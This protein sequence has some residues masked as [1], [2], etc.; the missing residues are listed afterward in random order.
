MDRSPRPEEV[1]AQYNTSDIH[2]L[3]RDPLYKP[4]RD[5]ESINP[6]ITSFLGRETDNSSDSFW[7]FFRLPDAVSGEVIRNVLF[8]ADSCHYEEN[9]E[10]LTGAWYTPDM[11]GVY[12]YD[13]AAALEQG[14]YRS[15]N[16]SYDRDPIQ[17]ETKYCLTPEAESDETTD[18]F[19]SKIYDEIGEV[20]RDELV[21]LVKRQSPWRET[22]YGDVID[23]SVLE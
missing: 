10:P 9:G 21:S 13:V 6:A 3:E 2:E 8:Y 17:P 23:F 4:D 22:E 11:T 19:V 12:S 20:S 5:V 14:P 16:M 18:A 1:F 7:D 15:F